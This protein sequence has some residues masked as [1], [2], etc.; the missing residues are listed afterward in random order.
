MSSSRANASA[1]QRRAGGDIPSQ[2]QQQQQPQQ[3]APQTNNKL[4]ISDAIALITLRLGRVENII[5]TL[6]ADLK[7]NTM[8]DN[9]IIRNIMERISLLENNRSEQPVASTASN[10]L[11][12]QKDLGIFKVENARL[13]QDIGELSGQVSDI[14]ELMLTLQSFTMETNKK[15][16][17]IVFSEPMMMQPDILTVDTMSLLRNPTDIDILEKIPDDN[18]ELSVSVDDLDSNGNQ[19]LIDDLDKLDDIDPT[20]KE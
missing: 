19:E 12:T 11:S 2:Q 8:E 14:K 9:I 5:Q 16:T 7:V 1:R 15:L 18:H 20:H 4:S 17:D 10:D 13:K 6:P 3:T